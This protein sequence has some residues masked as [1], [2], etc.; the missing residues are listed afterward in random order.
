MSAKHFLSAPTLIFFLI[1]LSFFQSS[2]SEDSSVTVTRL[3][4]D[5][6]SRES[7]IKNKAA[8]KLA[9]YGLKAEPAVPSLIKLLSDENGGVRTSAAYALRSIGTKKAITALE[10]YEK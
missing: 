5:L 10:K 9:S 2:C 7:K 6:S 8:L 4:K 1:S 3:N